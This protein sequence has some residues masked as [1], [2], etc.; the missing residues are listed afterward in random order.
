[1]ELTR[2]AKAL[3]VL[4]QGREKILGKDKSMV[5]KIE[6]QEPSRMIGKQQEPKRIILKPFH[7]LS[8]KHICPVKRVG[9]R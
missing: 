3:S 6:Q 2:L 5:G 9:T 7:S 1:M 8:L 4:K